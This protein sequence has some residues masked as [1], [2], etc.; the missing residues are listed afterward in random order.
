MMA[1]DIIPAQPI[2]PGPTVTSSEDNKR[3]QPPPRPNKK[4]KQRPPP[5]KPEDGKGTQ[6]DE[7]V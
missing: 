6:I 4:E 1:D 2:S 7:Y 5:I 3:R